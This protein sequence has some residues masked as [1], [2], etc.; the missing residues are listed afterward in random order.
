MT[1]TPPPAAAPTVHTV[2]RWKRV[3]LWPLVRLVRLWGMSLRFET[4]SEDVRNCAKCDVP[5]A[6]VL[7]HNRLFLASEIHRR[8]RPHRPLYALISA[9]K[10]G[11]LLTA[12]FAMVGGM[13]A[14]RGSTSNF[15]REAATALVQAQREGHD[16]GITPDGPRGPCYDLKPGAVIVP[17]RTGAPVL[18]IGGEFTSA[19]Q[20][21]SWDRFYLPL[22]FS[23]VRLHCE[24]IENERLADRD[25]AIELI[26]SRLLA[27]NPDRG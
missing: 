27:L 23:R 15:G 1:D 7:W 24:L 3:L 19:W 9:S 6:F 12:F 26:R 5:V 4:T 13:R 17:R 2:S 25:A 21:K 11:A 8:Y 18:L 10:D 22:P 16:I 14:V 20:L